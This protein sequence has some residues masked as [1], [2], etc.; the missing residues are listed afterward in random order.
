MSVSRAS[1]GLCP[2]ETCKPFF[3]GLDPKIYDF[4]SKANFYFSS[5]MV[6]PVSPSPYA[7]RRKDLTLV[8]CFKWFWIASRSTPVPLPW[9][10]VT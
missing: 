8:W 1:K 5:A 7:P 4:E 10:I 9:M 3:E 6:T 2:F